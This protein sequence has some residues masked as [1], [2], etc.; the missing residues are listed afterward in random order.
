MRL[1]QHLAL[2]EDVKDKLCR[3]ETGI[4]GAAGQR[5]R[6]IVGTLDA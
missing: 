3:N 1:G 2:F 6:R 4:I 5:V